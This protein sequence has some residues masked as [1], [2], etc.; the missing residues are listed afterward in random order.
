MSPSLTLHST[1]A[2]A[3]TEP[4]WDRLFNHPTLTYTELAQRLGVS[5]SCLTNYRLRRSTMPYPVRFCLEYLAAEASQ[6]AS[7]ETEQTFPPAYIGGLYLTDFD[8]TIGGYLRHAMGSAGIIRHKAGYLIPMEVAS[9]VL[10]KLT[11]KIKRGGFCTV[12]KIIDITTIHTL[13]PPY[14][15][16]A[17][18]RPELPDFDN[19]YDFADD[20]PEDISSTPDTSALPPYLQAILDST[21]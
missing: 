5:Y 20:T 1:Q 3:L 19:P 17:D 21:K 6:D 14:W 8:C 7:A 11:Q 15:N 12:Q 4:E 16:T 13:Y 9:K 10:Q 18:L 2:K